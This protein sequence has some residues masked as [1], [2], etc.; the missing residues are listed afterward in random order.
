MNLHSPFII[1][2]PHLS[3]IDSHNTSNHLRHDDHVTQMGLDYCGLLIRRCLLLGF[4]E[5]LDETHWA[6]LETAL[7][8][9]AG[10]GMDELSFVSSC[11]RDTRHKW[12]YFNE[13]TRN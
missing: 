2:H 5:L 4:S 11:E 12:A 9:T 13:L 3:V 8:A 6:T 10:T 1:A 7:E